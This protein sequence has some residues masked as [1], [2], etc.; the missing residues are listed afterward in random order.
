MLGAAN[1]LAE[2]DPGL[3][4]L[5]PIK[6]R[7]DSCEDTFEPV[8]GGLEDRCFISKSYD[9]SS[10][11]K[12]AAEDVLNMYERITG[13]PLALRLARDVRLRGRPGP[14]QGQIRGATLRVSAVPW[15]L[16]GPF[17]LV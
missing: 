5:G 11:F 3:A 7:F 1:P 17:G 12:S 2:L 9:D 14:L 15:A 8:A 13:T 16:R 4:L 6:E 10:H